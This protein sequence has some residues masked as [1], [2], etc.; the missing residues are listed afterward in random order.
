[1]L[2]DSQLVAIKPLNA[3]SVLDVV[4]ECRARVCVIGRESLTAFTFGALDV[5]M[6]LI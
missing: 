6:L 5:H 2:I 1:M 4:L 3:P